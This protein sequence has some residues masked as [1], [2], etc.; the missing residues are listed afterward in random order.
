MGEMPGMEAGA[1]AA[2]PAEVQ[3]PGGG[4]NPAWND[5]LGIL[6]TQLHGVVKPHLQKWDQGVNERFQQ[7]HSQYQPWKNIADQGIA[8]DDVMQAM[9]ILQTIN[10]NPQQ[11][12]EALAEHLGIGEQGDAEV[13]DEEYGAE[14]EVDP[15]IAQLQQGYENMAAIIVGQHEEQQQAQEDQELDDY[16]SGLTEK[17]GEYDERYVLAMMDSGMSGED[18][19]QSFQNLVSEKASAIN[20]PSAPSIL[21]PGGG[22]PSQAINPAELDDKGR[23]SLVAQMLQSVAQ[24]KG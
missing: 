11:V 22:T 9:T 19:V 2:A 1:A 15:R 6:P 5:L 4:D 21:S 17:F 14:E 3:Q 8:P 13:G 16:L 10:E 20:R 24:N 12:Y 18:A 23:R 7:V